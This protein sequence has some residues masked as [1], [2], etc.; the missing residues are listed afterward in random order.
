MGSPD[1]GQ[2]LV[3]DALELA[4]GDGDGEL[5]GRLLIMAA[6]LRLEA[7][8]EAEARPFAEEALKAVATLGDDGLIGRAMVLDAR[9]ELDRVG[10][11]ATLERFE[12]AL[13]LLERSGDPRQVVRLVMTRAYLHLEAGRLDAAESDAAYSVRMTAELAHPI[14]NA[15]SRLILVL[16]AIDRGE[17]DEAL[18]GLEAVVPI[19]RDAGYRSLVAYCAAA[20]AAIRAA[21][22]DA[23]G[24]AVRLGALGVEPDGASAPVLGGEGS[25]GIGNRLAAL[26]ESL[27]ETLGN[28]ELAKALRRGARAELESLVAEATPLG[29]T[30]P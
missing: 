29:A 14:G 12:E 27:G 13:R 1:G 24:A 9:A 16:V 2:A 6:D 26:R 25:R 4:R 5:L 21:R 11:E 20:D 17:L 10:Y 7:G 23:M 18:A 8:R 30:S 19:A 28:E 15:M 22:G 3:D